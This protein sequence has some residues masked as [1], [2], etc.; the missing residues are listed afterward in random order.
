MQ[1]NQQQGTQKVKI[2]MINRLLSTI[3]P[4]YCCG[5][6]KIGTLLCGSCKYYIIDESVL[7]YST[8][9]QKGSYQKLWIVGERKDVLQRVIGLFK[10][11]RAKSAYKILGD[12]LLE[13]LPNLPENTVIVPIPTTAQHR[14]ERGYD[15]MLL[16]AKYVAKKQQLSCRPLLKRRTSTQQ[17]QANAQTRRL[18]AQKAFFVTEKLADVPYLI[19][20]DVLTTG[21]TIEFAAKALQKAGAKTIWV[22]IIARQPSTDNNVSATINR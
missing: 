1:Y 6:N 8:N 2:T 19:L 13:T 11:E 16:V 21:A 14:R 3:A 7:N 20:D 15:H 18:Q 9:Y 5:C 22:G 10:F 17:R 4:H 12:L